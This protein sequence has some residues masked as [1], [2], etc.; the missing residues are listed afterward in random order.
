MGY[1]RYS[2][3]NTENKGAKFKFQKMITL[4]EG[5]P[6]PGNF[7]ENLTALWAQIVHPLSLFIVQL[8]LGVVSLKIFLTY[9]IIAVDQNEVPDYYEIIHNPMDF[10]TIRKK[11]EV[12]F[13][14][15]FLYLLSY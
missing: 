12:R 4:N 3:P 8:D 5:L 13:C 1:C 6:T 11:L 9:V 10:S 14:T 7:Q 2:I 15:W